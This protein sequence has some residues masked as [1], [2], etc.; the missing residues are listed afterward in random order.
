MKKFL[1]LAILAAVFIYDV[2]CVCLLLR[3]IGFVFSRLV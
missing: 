2:Y 1:F 3:F